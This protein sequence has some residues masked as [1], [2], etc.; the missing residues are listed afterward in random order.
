[1]P[2]P[3][4]TAVANMSVLIIILISF[5]AVR[6]RMA[7][8]WIDARTQP[9]VSHDAASIIYIGDRS[10]FCIRRMAAVLRVYPIESHFPKAVPISG[11]RGSCWSTLFSTCPNWDTARALATSDGYIRV[12]DPKGGPVD[13]A[14][15]P[16]NSRGRDFH[17]HHV[18]SLT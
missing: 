3:T 11:S 14:N 15:C 6:E 18:A 13:A 5:A 10:H 2:I 12:P 16:R 4:V 9:C 8:S 1:M 17:G 7:P